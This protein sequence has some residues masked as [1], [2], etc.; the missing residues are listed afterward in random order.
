MYAILYYSD[1]RKEVEVR[2]IGVTADKERAIKTA[3]DVV[4]KEITSPLDEFVMDCNDADDNIERY[5]TAQGT[6]LVEYRPV[7]IRYERIIT[8]DFEWI[9]KHP[10][11]FIKM[12]RNEGQVVADY[13]ANITGGIITLGMYLVSLGLCKHAAEIMAELGPNTNLTTVIYSRKTP[14][15]E[16]LGP[17]VR[18]ILEKS[19]SCTNG[20]DYFWQLCHSGVWAVVE[21]PIL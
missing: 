16:V 12:A 20:T 8:H 18:L 13:M 1:Y 17:F 4:S 11:A 15:K 10:D 2:I 3:F 5:V 6:V 9:F 7:E 14:H 19:Y 21:T